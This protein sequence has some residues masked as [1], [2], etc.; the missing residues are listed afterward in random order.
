MGGAAL[1][2]SAVAAG[3]SIHNGNVAAKTAKENAKMLAEGSKGGFQLPPMPDFIPADVGA[4]RKHVEDQNRE[5]YRLSDQDFSKRHG[6]TVAAEKIAESN[7]LRDQK[8]NSTLLPQMQAELIKAG[9]GDALNSFGDT[10]ANLEHGSAGEAS[11]ATNL[12]LGINNFQQQNRAN[13]A[14]SLSQIEAL[15]PRRQFG[16][17][18]DDVAGLDLANTQ[19]QNNFNQANYASTVQQQQYNQRLDADALKTQVGQNNVAA[20]A[21]AE[22]NAATAKL[23]ASGIG[24]VGDVA[25]KYYGYK[26]TP[27]PIGSAAKV[28]A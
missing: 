3:T 21:G 7:A 9:L 8:G 25:G 18:G 4:I 13:A 6:D 27:T 23:I 12:G 28:A 26:S 19:G 14:G 11:V 24:A 10:G 5:Q 1:A 2:G 16:L 15:F 17:T 20:Q 22:N